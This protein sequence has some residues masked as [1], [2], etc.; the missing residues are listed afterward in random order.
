MEGS[1]DLVIEIVAPSSAEIDRVRKAAT[2]ATFGVP[3]YWVV[4][5]E[6]KTIQLHA[7]SGGRYRPIVSRDGLIRSMQV[8]GLVIDP[9]EVFL[10]PS[11]LKTGDDLRPIQSYL[12]AQIVHRFHRRF[13]HGYRA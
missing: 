1:P 3:E 10:V 12:Q 7:L 9:V 11:W 5:P 13:T 2:Y 4:N 6:A 8:E